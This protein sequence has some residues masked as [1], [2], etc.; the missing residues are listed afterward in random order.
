MGYTHYWRRTKE[1]DLPVMKK[2]VDDFTKIVIAISPYVDLA[3]GNGEN[4]A[5]VSYNEIRFNGNSKCGHPKEDLG[6][7]WPSDDAGGINNPYKED[8]RNGNW[9]AGELLQKRCCG[10]DCSHETMLFERIK[11]L[12]DWNKPNEQKLYYNF[13]K[14]A[15]KPYDIAVIALLIIAKHYLN[16]K[17]VVSSDG[18]DNQWFDGKLLC[19]QTLEYG[20]EFKLD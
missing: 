6:I 7:T 17:I 5:I 19:Q 14:T 18:T 2:I 13:C 12:Q 10:G 15:F 20:L 4:T 3:D 8:V 9:F 11:T 16:D 1:I